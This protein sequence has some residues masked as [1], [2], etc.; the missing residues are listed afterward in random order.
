MLKV[1]DSEPLVSHVLMICL[2]DGNNNIIISVEFTSLDIIVK[3]LSVKATS[4]KQNWFA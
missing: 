3:L 4:L 1:D 2:C